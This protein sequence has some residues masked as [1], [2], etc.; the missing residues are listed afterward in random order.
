MSVHDEE[1]PLTMAAVVMNEVFRTLIAA[2]FSEAQALRLIAYMLEDLTF[3]DASE[4][5]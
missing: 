1:S 5:D 2:G 3:R 4:D